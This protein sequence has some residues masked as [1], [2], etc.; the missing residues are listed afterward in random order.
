MRRLSIAATAACTLGLAASAQ[1]AGT[2]RVVVDRFTEQFEFRVDCS[3]FGP[4][5][6]SNLVAGRQKVTVTEVRDGSGELLQTVFHINVQETETNSE[7]GASLPLKTAIHEIWDYR[8]NTRTVNGKVFL[9][10]QRGGGTYTHD[11]GRIVMTLDTREAS[12]VAGPHEAFFGGGI[13]VP[14]C[15]ALADAD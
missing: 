2:Q 11:T 7:T 8:T 6:F 5:N 9:G 1:A 10:T 3:D 12:F 15:A 14:V 13:D 4:Y